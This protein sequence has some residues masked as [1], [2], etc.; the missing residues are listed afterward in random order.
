[1]SGVSNPYRF[2]YEAVAASQTAQVLGGTGAVGDYVHRL[3]IT[4]NTV[5]TATVTLIDG[6]GGSAQTLA[7]LVGA[8]GLVAG[9]YSVEVN[10][11]SRVGAWQ[12]TTGAGATVVAV[13]QFSA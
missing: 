5:A 3:I 12:V 6:T 13:G 11:V 1:M 7:L 4:V 2:Q 8:A 10:A 9:V